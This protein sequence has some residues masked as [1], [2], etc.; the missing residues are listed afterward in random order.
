[1]PQEGRRYSR[2]VLSHKARPAAVKNASRAHHQRCLSLTRDLQTANEYME[3]RVQQVADRKK[4]IETINAFRESKV[5]KDGT[6][7]L[8]SVWAISR[9]LLQLH[10]TSH[11]PRDMLYLVSMLTKC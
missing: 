5:R 2:H 7:F 1:M 11:T 4:H 8:T 3:E 9:A 10:T 6:S